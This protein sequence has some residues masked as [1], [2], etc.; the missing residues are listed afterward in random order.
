MGSTDNE[1]LACADTKW[2][3]YNFTKVSEG[4]LAQI[5]AKYTFRIAKHPF[6]PVKQMFLQIS[7]PHQKYL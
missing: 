3:N 5:A 7:A 6:H 4:F 1:P 2:N